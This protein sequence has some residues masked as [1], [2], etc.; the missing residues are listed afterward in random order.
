MSFTARLTSFILQ[1]YKTGFK[2][3]L[4]YIK[5]AVVVNGMVN[6]DEGLFSISRKRMVP[7]KNT[8]DKKTTMLTAATEHWT[9]CFC[10]VLY[11]LELFDSLVLEDCSELK[12]VE[13][14]E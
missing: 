1:Q 6:A 7:A 11:L 5:S 9:L 8:A 3:E 4:K 10:I 13:S 12:N 2:V 14:E